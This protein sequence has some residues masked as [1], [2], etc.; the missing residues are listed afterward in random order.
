MASILDRRTGGGRDGA[1]KPQG[2]AGTGTGVEGI[3]VLVLSLAGFGLLILGERMGL[4]ADLAAGGVLVIVLAAGLALALFSTTTRL[5]RFMVGAGH[6]AAFGFASV[7]S[8]LLAFAASALS[9]AGG[10]VGHAA[11]GWLSIG[12][13]CGLAV[14]GF[15]PW[16]DFDGGAAGTEGAIRRDPDPRAEGRGALALAALAVALAAIL[17]VLFFLPRMLDRLGEVSGWSRGWLW[18]LLAIFA[19]AMPLLGGLRGMRRA[20]LFVTGIALVSVIIPLLAHFAAAIPAGMPVLAIRI[21]PDRAVAFL[22]DLWQAGGGTAAALGFAIGLVARQ[23]GAAVSGGGRR[24]LAIVFGGALGFLLALSADTGGVL[25]DAIE[26]RLRGQGPAQW[27]VFVFDDALRGWVTACGIV[28]EDAGTAARACGAGGTRA[29]LRPDALGFSPRL[30]PVAL[31]LSMGLPAILGFIWGVLM[32]LVNII[33]LGILVHAGTSGLTERMIF[34]LLLPRA[35]RASRLAMARLATLAL[36][37]GLFLADGRNMRLDPA[38]FRWGLLSTTL[39]VAAAMSG[40]GILAALR[41]V[42]ARWT[43]HARPPGG[44]AGE[45]A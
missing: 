32:P 36:L 5:A 1:A 40:Y 25:L 13:V 31:A 9:A 44:I 35:L 6:G 18:G 39:I 22:R 43:R 45:T 12:V 27:P 23:G 16:R 26:A 15:H 33:A 10:L 29:P 28:P 37:L 2:K 17:L 4:A 20:A 38:L 19:G 41:A 24:F 3:L 8:C 11:A 7:L 21:G 14:P 30:A 42:R 34:R